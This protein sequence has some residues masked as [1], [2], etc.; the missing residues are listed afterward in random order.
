MPSAKINNLGKYKLTA[1]ADTPDAVGLPLRAIR[2]PGSS[3]APVLRTRIGMPR[4]IAG[5]IAAGWSTLLPNDANSQT[6]S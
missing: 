4:V 2:V 5:T 1:I 6:S 3:G